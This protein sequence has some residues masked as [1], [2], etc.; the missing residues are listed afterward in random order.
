MSD[1]VLFAVVPYL[2]MVA[3]I[4]GS[5]LRISATVPVATVA[6]GQDAARRRRIVAVCAIALAAGHLVLLGAPHAVLRWNRSMAR[7]LLAEGAGICLASLCMVAVARSLWGRRAGSSTRPQPQPLGDTVACTLLGIEIGTGLSLA[8]LYRWAS[9][10]SVV[11]LTPYAVSVLKLGP[12]VELVAA[13][14]FLV[15]L[16]VFCTCAILVVLPF[17]TVGSLAFVP[18]QRVV[19][20]VLAPLAPAY[21]SARASIVARI[22][23][24]VRVPGSLYEEES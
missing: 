8:V 5:V 2:A 10:W 16:H 20:T 1:H 13:T 22:R 12:R 4:L 7:L 9:S 23:R 15:R 17:T 18:V 19:R 21:C 14:P 11:T 3:F 6:P 24:I